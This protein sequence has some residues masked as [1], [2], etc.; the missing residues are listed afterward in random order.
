MA[1][2]LGKFP[3]P[4]ELE[5]LVPDFELCKRIPAG[6]F[7]DS[8]LVYWG[9]KRLDATF[10]VVPR[11]ELGPT[12]H[13]FIAK[14]VRVLFPAPTLAEIMDELVLISS[15]PHCYWIGG[16]YALADMPYGDVE[17]YDM[18]SP[19][20]AALKLWLEVNNQKWKG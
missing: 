4:K 14:G 11:A 2:L 9:V 1:K 15:E 7:A 3:K 19:V 18:T 16:W 12:C 10:E 17:E 13:M 8:V 5:N 20:T 6:A